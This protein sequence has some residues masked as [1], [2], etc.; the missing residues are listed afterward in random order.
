MLNKDKLLEALEK[1]ISSSERER[2]WLT[3]NEHSMGK[4]QLELSKTR[5]S[6][7]KN[8]VSAVSVATK[9]ITE[10]K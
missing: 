8:I 7:N 3:Q 1:V 2:N 6:A 5:I 4:A 9:L 10:E